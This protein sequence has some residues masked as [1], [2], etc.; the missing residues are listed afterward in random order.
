MNNLFINLINPQITFKDNI[1]S[2]EPNKL[3]PLFQVFNIPSG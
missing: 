3:F 1:L 2:T